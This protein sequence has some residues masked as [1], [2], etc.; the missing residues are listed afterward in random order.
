MDI[1]AEVEKVFKSIA[2]DQGKIDAFKKDPVGA[3][4]KI[5][6]DGV[7]QDLISK[8]VEGV[9]AKLTADQLSGVAGKIGGLFKK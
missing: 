7:A 8:I 1:K 2:G 5:L 9:K 6:G 3:V 4:K